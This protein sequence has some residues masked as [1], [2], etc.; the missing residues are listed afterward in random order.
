MKVPRSARLALLFLAAS[1]FQPISSWSLRQL[2]DQVRASTLPTQQ[3][4]THCESCAFLRRGTDRAR[5]G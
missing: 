1:L 3:S 5:S 2:C 4:A